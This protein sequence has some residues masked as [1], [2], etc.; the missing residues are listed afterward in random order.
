MEE[1]SEEKKMLKPLLSD[2]SSVFIG[3]KNPKSSDSRDNHYDS[4]ERVT[5]PERSLDEI[6]RKLNDLEAEI[7]GSDSEHK[8]TLTEAEIKGRSEELDDIKTAEPQVVLSEEDFNEIDYAIL[9][10]VSHGIVTLKDISRKLQMKMFT[11]EKHVDKLVSVRY[12]RFFRHLI[13]TDRGLNAVAAYEKTE[14]EEVWKPIDEFISS[15]GEV[16]EAQRERMQRIVDK[17]LLVAVTVLIIFIIYF[18]FF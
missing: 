1:R 2:D 11:V 5:V 12:L 18:G 7:K 3:K 6:L 16:T 14:S 4:G 17:V 15:V 9:K 8:Q 13:L 10:A